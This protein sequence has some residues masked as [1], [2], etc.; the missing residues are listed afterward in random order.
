MPSGLKRVPDRNPVKV[1]AD[2]D[3]PNREHEEIL[4]SGVDVWNKWRKANPN[5][6]PHLA[7]I[8]YRG[9]DFSG[10]DFDNALLP[11]SILSRCKFRGATF[12]GADLRGASLRRADLTNTNLD[13]AILRHSSL[14][15]CIVQGAVFTN[16]HIY[17]I[18]AW[19]LIGKPK[20]QANMIMKAK[21]E[22][23]GITIDDI[24]VAQLIFLLLHNENIRDVINTITSKVVLILGRFTPARKAVLDAIREELRKYDLL[25]V[26][27]DFDKPS[28]RDIHETVTTLARLARF[29]VADITDP[30]SIP[31]ELVSIV[32]TMPSLPVQPLLQQGQEP[33]SM[34]GH[35]KRY[36]WVLEIY[37]YDDLDD[38]L[39]ALEKKVIAPAEDKAKELTG[40]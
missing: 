25:P 31:Q 17:G 23:A 14:A 8:R 16:C 30:K 12:R 24:E 32:E 19:S 3:R 29:V 36:P 37:K 34:Y 11:F 26:L 35:I 33:W 2:F 21:I 15:E 13:G 4:K 18:S 38:L 5:I 10:C 40:Q 6:I 28:T 20:D 39:G 7:Y 22:E 1:S 27:F 9:V